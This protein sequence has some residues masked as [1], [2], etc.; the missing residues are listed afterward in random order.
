[1]ESALVL[2]DFPRNETRT[3]SP[4]PAHPQTGTRVSR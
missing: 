1:L 4:F 3:V 2:N